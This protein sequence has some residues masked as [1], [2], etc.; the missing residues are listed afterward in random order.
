MNNQPKPARSGETQPEAG[1]SLP[2]LEADRYRDRCQSGLRVH[3]AIA[4]YG[5][6]RGWIG[7]LGFR[8]WAAEADVVAAPPVCAECKILDLPGHFHARGCSKYVPLQPVPY[9]P[10]GFV[11]TASGDIAGFATGNVRAPR[12][13]IAERRAA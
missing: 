5:P 13:R 10:D 7:T 4:D 3:Y 8:R 11:R 9:G 1:R 6:A 2:A 12:V